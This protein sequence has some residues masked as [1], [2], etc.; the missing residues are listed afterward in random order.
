M[1]SDDAEEV[2]VDDIDVSRSEEF[3]S[4]V[5]KQASG[6]FTKSASE[7]CAGGRAKGRRVDFVKLELTTSNG[8]STP[9]AFLLP[10]SIDFH[11]STGCSGS[12]PF[13]SLSLETS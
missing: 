11:P 8:H 10:F 4:I 13:T 6:K 7:G 5:V 9:S 12:R 1:R 2:G 3:E